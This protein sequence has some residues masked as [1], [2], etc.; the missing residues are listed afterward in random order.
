MT[1]ELAIGAIFLVSAFTQSFAGFGLALVAVPLLSLLLPIRTAVALQFPLLWALFAFQAWHYRRHVPWAAMRPLVGGTLAGIL[2]GAVLLQRLPEP[3]LVR[4]LAVFLAAVVLFNLVPAGRRTTRRY[5][6]SR[7]WGR[8][9]GALS[10]S[11]LGAYT[12]G[13]PPVVLYVMSVTDHAR[14]AKGF[15]AAFF[16]L[17]LLLVAALHASAGLFTRKLLVLSA[18]YAPAVA[19]GAAAGLWVF[20]RAS[21]RHYRRFVDLL[22][23]G[24]A[25]ALWV[26]G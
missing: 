13:G 19:L 4:A 8:L 25:L 3:V 5:A 7:W 9:C 6:R 2:V 16:A 11:F 14:T 17:Q 1:Q 22:L 23:L 10:G 24:T 12:I 20:G 15:M 18:C 21:N 26:R